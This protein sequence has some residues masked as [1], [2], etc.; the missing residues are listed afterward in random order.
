MTVYQ[1]G[2]FERMLTII[3]SHSE[4]E[5]GASQG[6]LSYKMVAS[7]L[8]LACARYFY[9]VLSRQGDDFARLFWSDA[10]GGSPG[11]VN[12]EKKK[13]PRFGKNRRD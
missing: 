4:K 1:K 12:E 9:A 5:R 8:R 2:T 13:K 11:P 6:P 7:Y 3:V 10:F